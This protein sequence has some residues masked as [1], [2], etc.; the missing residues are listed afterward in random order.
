MTR[1]SV[2]NQSGGLEKL[3]IR[4]FHEN[5]LVFQVFY[6]Q[7]NSHLASNLVMII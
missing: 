7:K 6:P 3:I 5:I 4:E 1:K 2:I